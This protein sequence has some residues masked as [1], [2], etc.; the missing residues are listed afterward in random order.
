MKLKHLHLCCVCGNLV[1]LAI[2]STRWGKLPPCANCG[3]NSWERQPGLFD[4]FDQRL[5]EG[6]ND[7]STGH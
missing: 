5:K 6:G 7:V 4:V 2:P 1:N 3:E